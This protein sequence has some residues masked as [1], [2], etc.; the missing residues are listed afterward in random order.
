MKFTRKIVGFRSGKRRNKVIA[1]IGYLLFVAGLLGQKSDAPTAWDGF[2][3]T[4]AWILLFLFIVIPTANLFSIRKRLFFFNRLSIIGRVFGVLGYALLSLIVFCTIGFG[5]ESATAKQIEAKQQAQQQVA[6]KESA[7]SKVK[8]EEEAK[9]KV[10]A[11]EEAKAKAKAK[12]DAKAKA[13][14][15]AKAKAEAQA[16]AQAEVAAKAQAEAAV[17]AKAE[18]AAK[19]Q[20]EAQA[21]AQAEAAAKAQAEAQAK[22]QAEAAAKAKAE[23]AAKAQAEAAAKAQQATVQII[24]ISNPAP[25][26]SIATLRAKV[27]P[28]ATAYIA[29]HY[30]SG[31]S[32]AQGLEPKQADSNG[33]VSWSW[34]VGGRSTLGTVPVTVSCNNASA[35]TQFTVV[36]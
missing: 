34:H 27:A 12:A 6:V 5:M 19:A 11:E 32:T 3:H 10:K 15:E 8:A 29:V 17:K 25:R 24:S 28:G 13:E 30:E 1:I 20:A 33:N 31:D 23:A 2:V 9:A 36:H 7:D 4:L 26:N 35:E 16:K 14:K 18:A 22:A 21:K